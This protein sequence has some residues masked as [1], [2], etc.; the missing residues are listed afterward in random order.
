MKRTLVKRPSIPSRRL[1][2]IVVSR[3]ETGEADLIVT[4]LTRELGLI[5]AMA[6]NARHSLKRFGG[7]LLRPGMAAWFDFKVNPRFELAFVERGEFNPKVSPLPSNPVSLALTSWALELIRAF[8]APRNPAPKS[9]NL[10]LRYLGRLAVCRNFQSPAAEARRLSIIFTKCYL[11]LAG[12]GTNFKSCQICNRSAS[13]F[14]ID[15]YPERAITENP[16]TT[17]Q[18]QNADW[19]WDPHTGGIFCPQCQSY[20]AA[21]ASVLP[22]SLLKAL[23]KIQGHSAKT[24]ILA[25]HLFYAEDYFYRMASL[26]A[27]R[28]F[29]SR[30]VITALLREN[31]TKAKNWPCDSPR[32]A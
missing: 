16:S 13:D 27:G 24:E 2:A 22:R 28:N 15:L 21:T 11:E 25:E 26:Q 1:G 19:F 23:V 32:A 5:S 30:S 7:V 29:K 17:L 31:G 18:P 3:V 4:F 10:L 14:K 20:S 12:F 9:F 6:K 8:E